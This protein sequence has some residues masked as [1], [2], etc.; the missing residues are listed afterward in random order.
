MWSQAGDIRRER[1]S[2]ALRNLVKSFDQLLGARC[3]MC[4]L[5]RPHVGMV[6]TM[7]VMAAIKDHKRV[8][9]MLRAAQ[10]FA[11]G[12][13]MAELPCKLQKAR[14]FGGQGSRLMQD[15]QQ[16]VCSGREQKLPE[17]F[18]ACRIAVTTSEGFVENADDA[19]SHGDHLVNERFILPV[20]FEAPVLGVGRIAGQFHALRIGRQWAIGATKPARYHA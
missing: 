4:A 10:C 2:G 17:Q 11:N 6:E 7:Q 19:L 5:G 15:D 16:P 20:A 13:G 9:D 12:A 18:D 3:V 8:I 14:M 1:W